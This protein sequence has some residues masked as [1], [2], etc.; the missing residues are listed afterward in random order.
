MLNI[1]YLPSS[2]SPQSKTLIL[3][4]AGTQASHT[5]LSIL[6]TQK[7]VPPSPDRETDVHVAMFKKK[8][9]GGGREDGTRFSMD[10]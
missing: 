7:Q 6:T 9:R 5:F 10:A 8:K 1:K 4:T 2:R 3:I